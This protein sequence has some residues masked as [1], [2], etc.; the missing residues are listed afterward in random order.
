MIKAI[1]LSLVVTLGTIAVHGGAAQADRNLAGKDK[2]ILRM[3]V[4]FGTDGGPASSKRLHVSYNLQ[5][6]RLSEQFLRLHFDTLQPSLERNTDQVRNL[7]VTDDV[8]ELLLLNPFEKEEAESVDQIWKSVRP[9]QGVIHVEYD[10]L[11]ERASGEKIPSIPSLRSRRSC[12]QRCLNKD[13]ACY[14]ALAK[15]A[16]PS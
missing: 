14:I 6:T 2:P 1:S 16:S 15:A 7:H 5:N 12:D 13:G 9:V 8:G 10:V 4:S 3:K 11:D